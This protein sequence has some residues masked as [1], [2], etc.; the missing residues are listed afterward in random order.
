MINHM[1]ILVH[2]NEKRWS[3]NLADQGC[4]PCLEKRVSPKERVREDIHFLRS[5]FFGDFTFTGGSLVTLSAKRHVSYPSYKSYV[6]MEISISLASIEPMAKEHASFHDA[7]QK[8]L[9]GHQLIS[10]SVHLQLRSLSDS[11]ARVHPA[12]V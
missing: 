3:V 9:K 1:G 11:V 2:G 6:C 4:V 5:V 10:K 7:R 8:C 12:G